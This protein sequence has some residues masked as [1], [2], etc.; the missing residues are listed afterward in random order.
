M[1]SSDKRSA[2]SANTAAAERSNRD[3]AR[4]IAG[5]I[6]FIFGLFV[7]AAVLSYLFTWRDDASILTGVDK[8][9]PIADHTAAN[10]CG[11]AGAWLGEFIVGRGFGLFGV[12]LPVMVA[13]MGVRIIRRRPWL[14][15]HSFLSS[16]IVLILGSLSLGAAFDTAGEVFGSG[17]G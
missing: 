14:V 9:N 5:L 13:M 6:V 8:D 3:S 1:A 2:S 17:W 11:T 12:I 15:T 7:T 10:V 16:L 4:W